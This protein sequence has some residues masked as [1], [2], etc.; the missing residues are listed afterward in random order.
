MGIRRAEA[1]LQA[2]QHIRKGVSA[3]QWVRDMRAI[4]LGYRHTTMLADYRTV[5]HLEK[6]DGVARF[7]RRDRYPTSATMATVSWD[8]EKEF[9]YQ[10]KVKSIVRPGEPLYERFIH[11]WTDAPM[12][13]EM[14]EAE[15][16]RRYAEE[17]KYAE[18]VITSLQAWT[19][20]R[21]VRE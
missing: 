3:A 9:I 6:K 4:G 8:I 1:I 10:V 18:Q 21:R 13:P 15:A 12:T 17:E 20:M 11:V 2:R 14:A 7:I 5:L 16:L 19:P